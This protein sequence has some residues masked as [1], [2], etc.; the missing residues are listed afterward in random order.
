MIGDTIRFFEIE[1]CKGQPGLVFDV[2]FPKGGNGYQMMFS[3][4]KSA[5]DELPYPDCNPDIDIT[6]PTPDAFVR[7]L[8]EFFQKQRSGCLKTLME[9]LQ[10]NIPL[11]SAASRVANKEYLYALPFDRKKDILVLREIR[12]DFRDPGGAIHQ[13]LSKTNADCVHYPDSQAPGS[14]LAV[15]AHLQKFLLGKDQLPLTEHIPKAH[16]S[17]ENTFYW[18]EPEFRL[19]H[20]PGGGCAA[21]LPPASNES[22]LEPMEPMK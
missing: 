13:F 19:K 8:R 18:N 5:A 11:G 7:A 3:L 21:A 20:V 17:R 6:T 4:K 22:Q 12:I 1:S 9:D 16:Q 15:S 14:F 10:Q 2:T